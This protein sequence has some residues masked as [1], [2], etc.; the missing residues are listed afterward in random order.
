M[1]RF[2]CP[3]CGKSIKIADE[4]AVR[5]GKCPGCQTP[6]TVPAAAPPA[7]VEPA[8]AEAEP[9]HAAAESEAATIEVQR[10]KPDKKPPPVELGDLWWG[11]LC[12][13]IFMLGLAV[14]LYNELSHLESDGGSFRIWWGIALAYKLGGKWGAVGL[15][16]GFGIIFVLWGIKQF[17]TGKE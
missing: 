14:W 13:G 10:T 7:D 6:V 9:A 2:A 16:G 5:R 17:K 4:Y 15:I 8:T 1:I 3:T 12:G 11:K